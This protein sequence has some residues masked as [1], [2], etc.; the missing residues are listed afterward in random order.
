MAKPDRRK[1]MRAGCYPGTVTVRRWGIEPRI[2]PP[3]VAV[4]S[5]VNGS[6]CLPHPAVPFLLCTLPLRR[7]FLLRAISALIVHR[8][9]PDSPTFGF[10][11]R[12]SIVRIHYASHLHLKEQTPV[13]PR[14]VTD[15]IYVVRLLILLLRSPSPNLL[16]FPRRPFRVKTGWRAVTLKNP[17]CG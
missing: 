3:L 7:S 13:S 16:R 17:P 12:T 1:F 10:V 9:L 14:Q 5:M 11:T 6:G 15:R 2:S 8:E 4:V